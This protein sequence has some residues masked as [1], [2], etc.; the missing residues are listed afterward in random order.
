MQR[1]VMSLQPEN[2]R[3]RSGAAPRM[4][5]ARIP[6]TDEGIDQSGKRSGLLPPAGEIKEE[7]RERLTSLPAPAPATRLRAAEPHFLHPNK[8]DQ[9]H[10]LQ[11][12]SPAPHHQL[13]TGRSLCVRFEVL[14]R[15]HDHWCQIR[16]HAYG[17]HVLLDVFSKVNNCRIFIRVALKTSSVHSGVWSCVSQRWRQRNRRV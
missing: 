17:D 12:G 15:T 13:S 2:G 7:P 9:R 5:S 10:L 14:R 3:A 16:R 8:Q 6:S 11:H 4:Q 1:H